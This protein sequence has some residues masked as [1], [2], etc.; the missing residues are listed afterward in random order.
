MSL[1]ITSEPT[2]IQRHI[3]RRPL[4]SFDNSDGYLEM[5]Q[6]TTAGKGRALLLVRHN[7]ANHEWAYARNPST[8]QLDKADWQRV[9]PFE[10]NVSRAVWKETRV[11]SR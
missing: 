5:L 3:G 6:W 10:Q 1:M 8:G 7:D 9:F 2:A 4:A 11:A